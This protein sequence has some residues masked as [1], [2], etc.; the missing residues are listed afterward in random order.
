MLTDPVTSPINPPSR[1]MYGI[2]AAVITVFIRL[3]AALPEGVAFSI[4][5]ASKGLGKLKVE[6]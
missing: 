6:S 1:V 3:F 4:L 5:I 2:I